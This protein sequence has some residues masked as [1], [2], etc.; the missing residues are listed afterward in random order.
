MD[1]ARL[2]VTGISM[3]F[4]GVHALRDVDFSVQPGEVVALIG[5]NGSGKT[6]LLNVICGYY[7]PDGGT[8]QVGG[9][10]VTG[11]RPY[12]I[13]RTGLARTFQTPS[14]P[15]T[16]VRDA[17]ASSRSTVPRVSMIETMLRLGRYR[18]ARRGDDETVAR[19]L[20]LTCLGPVAD[21][22]APSLPLG[23]RRVLELARSLAGEPRV[24]LLD[25]VASGLDEGEIR[26]LSAVVQ[27]IRDSGGS[28]LLVEHNFA[29]VRSLADRVVVL[30]R[31]EVVVVDTPDAVAHHPE[32]LQQYLGGPAAAAPR[33]EGENVRG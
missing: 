24:L 5:P 29:L 30:S 1:G 17:I 14:I 22:Q 2:D 7:R 15:Q 25:E 4:G 26:G 32:V 19:L 6:T 21:E 28:V 8:V 11:L 23:T 18:R 10:P 27:R 13:A 33:A 12:R 3:A 20:A 16:T 31:G 9:V